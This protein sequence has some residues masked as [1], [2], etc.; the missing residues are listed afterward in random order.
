[1]KLLIITQKVNKNDQI[2]GFFHA[3]LEEFSKQVEQLTVICLEEGEHDLPSNVKVYSLKKE[4]E[5]SKLKRLLLFY[6]Y[7]IEERKNYNHVFVHMNQIYVILGSLVWKLVSKRVSLWYAHGSVSFTLRIAERLT[8][9]I[10]TS[11][12][13]GFRLASGKKCIVGQGIDA[14]HFIPRKVHLEKIDKLNVLTV[15][16]V[17]EIKNIVASIELLVKKANM[18]LH[19]VGDAVTSKDVVYKQQC[20]DLANKLHVADRVMWHG[21]VSYSDLPRMYQQVEI[22]L[23]LS[24][25]GSLDKTILEALSSGLPVVTCNDAARGILGVTLVDLDDSER[26]MNAIKQDTTDAAIQAARENII[27]NYSL[28]GLVTKITQKLQK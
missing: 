25:T 11:T 19:L 2:L 17:S 12:E 24:N 9:I 7:I 8:N 10:F 21:T 16:R 4:D 15:G 5:S 26:I 18:I 13:K 27:Y 3:W 22:F 23:N 28:V 14:K 6:K 1:M 20:I